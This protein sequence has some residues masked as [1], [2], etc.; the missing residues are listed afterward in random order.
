[1]SF[2]DKTGSGRTPEAIATEILATPLAHQAM[3]K[4][5]MTDLNESLM[6]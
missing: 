2:V 4:G 1:M 6:S 5:L 3:P